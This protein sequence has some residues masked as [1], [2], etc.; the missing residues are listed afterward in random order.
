MQITRIAAGK[1]LNSIQILQKNENF[2]ITTKYNDLKIKE[3]LEKETE[4][5]RILM[6]EL[7]KK[8]GT[9]P[10]GEGMVYIKEEFIQEANKELS[11]FNS[12]KITLPD[13]KFSL[14]ELDKEIP[15]EALETFLPFIAD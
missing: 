13:L 11:E 12:Q 9:E 3:I 4:L 7:A 1:L 6:E 14:E 10:D 2:S 5:N 15:W 8:Y